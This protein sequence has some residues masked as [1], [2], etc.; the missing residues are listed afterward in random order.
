MT[1]QPTQFDK[2]LA[3]FL[4]MAAFA[5]WLRA[6]APAK[7]AERP[8]TVVLAERDGLKWRKGNLHTHTHWSDGDHYLEMVGLW[9]K[10]RGYDFLGITDHNTIDDAERWVD[11]EKARGKLPA[12]EKLQAQFPQ[13]WIVERTIDNRRE[14]RLKTYAEVAERLNEPGQFLM[15]QGEEIS[16]RFQKRPIHLN[17]TNLK[18]AIPPLGGDSVSETIQRNVDAVISQRERTGQPMF[19]HLNHPNFGWGVTAEDLMPIRGEQ[20]FEVYNGHPSVNNAG[21]EKHVSCERMWDL[22]NSFRLTDLELPIMYGLGTDDGHNYHEIPSRASEPGRAW[23][24]V[25]SDALTPEALIA[26]ME[27]GRFYSTNGVSLNRIEIRPDRLTVD[28]KPEEGITYRIDFIGTKRDF[29]HQSE[30]M[31]DA[32]GKPLDGVTRRYS[33]QIG[34]VLK[35]VEGTSGEYSFAGD[36][37]YVRATVTSSKL[38]PNPA[39][40]GDK[41][42][43]WVQPVVVSAK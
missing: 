4:V 7:D 14:I 16:D 23:V 38:H 25:L 24:M 41:E 15:I 17:A 31:R 27:A 10:E 12:F 3:C 6:A 21:D 40:V 39:E 36:E 2:G 19:V 9:Y 37:L 43:A 35:S 1:Y 30:P 42:K 8:R 29:D 26:A 33:P 11:P 20:F 13:D 34:Q 22:V 5:V 18:E 28:V 32:E